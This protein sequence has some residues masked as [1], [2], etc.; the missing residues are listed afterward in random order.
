MLYVK[1]KF[2]EEMDSLG[3]FLSELT[4]DKEAGRAA[5]GIVVSADA[6][7]IWIGVATV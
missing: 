7:L 6:I 4:F 5:R 2:P 1:G 3:L